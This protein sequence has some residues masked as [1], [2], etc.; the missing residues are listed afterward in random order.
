MS[1]NFQKQ[2]IEHEQDRI[3]KEI[4]FYT[5]KYNVDNISRTKAYL[6]FYRT[7]PEIQWA[8]LASMVSRNAGWNMCDLEGST[9]PKALSIAYRRQLF[10]TYEVANYLIFKDVFPQLLLYHYSV[11]YKRPLFHLH[12]PFL[13]SHFIRKEWEYFWIHRDQK[14]LMTALIINE[15]NVIQQPVIEQPFFRENVFQSGLF[16]LQDLLHFSTVLFPT[17]NGE[18]YG[19]TVHQFKNVSSRIQ[20]GKILACILFNEDRYADFYDFAV[21]TE[22]TGSREDYERFFPNGKWRDTPYLRMVF[23]VVNHQFQSFPRWDSFRKVKEKWKEPIVLSNVRQITSWYER[24]Q[25]QVRLFAATCD[26][27]RGLFC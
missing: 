26:L 9:L 10:L 4:F 23:P 12:T 8:F 15:Q 13:I 11:K 1:H 22:H 17:V 7:Y 27:F 6:K 2:R 5:N 3:I 25:K 20:L 14:R 19:A 16:L 21:K 24:K 18:L